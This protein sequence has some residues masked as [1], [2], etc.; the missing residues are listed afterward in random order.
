MV[1]KNQE[2][3]NIVQRRDYFIAHSN[4]HSKT[5]FIHDKLTLNMF[6]NYKKLDL[7]GN[8]I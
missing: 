5:Q 1:D 6:V 3:I 7:Q 8:P 2:S 4:Y